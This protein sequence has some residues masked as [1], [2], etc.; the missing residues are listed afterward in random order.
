MPGRCRPKQKVLLEK[1]FAAGDEPI[2]EW[3]ALTVALLDHIA[4]HVRR[5]SRPRRRS[6]CRW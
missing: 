5:P 4:E 3:R 6:A 2:V 1:A